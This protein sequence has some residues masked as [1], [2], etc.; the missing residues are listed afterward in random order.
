MTWEKQNSEREGWTQEKNAGGTK[1]LMIVS[2]GDARHFSVSSH[3]FSCESGGKPLIVLKDSFSNQVNKKVNLSTRCWCGGLSDPLVNIPIIDTILFLIFRF[4][5]LQT[6]YLLIGSIVSQDLPPP[7]V[8]LEPRHDPTTTVVDPAV[9]DGSFHAGDHRA[10]QQQHSANDGPS[11]NGDLTTSAPE[12][13][14]TLITQAP[15]PFSCYQCVN[16]TAKADLVPQAC[17]EGVEMCFV[18]ARVS[19]V[20]FWV[21]EPS[22][23]SLSLK[24]VH[25]RIDNTTRLVRR[26]CSL[27]KIQCTVPQDDHSNPFESVTCCTGHKCNDGTTVKPWHF[28]LKLGVFILLSFYV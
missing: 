16:C 6:G 14:T 23:L 21:R 27:T 3:S 1:N 2:Y 7:L 11:D 19:F 25:K 28:L 12:S 4:W 10:H 18:S 22:F 9:N 24:K 17:G 15:E 8:H 26:G 13:S 20:H 5:F